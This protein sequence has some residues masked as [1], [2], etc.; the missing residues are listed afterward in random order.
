[1][2]YPNPVYKNNIGW[3]VF[4]GVVVTGA[5]M[6]AYGNYIVAWESRF[7]DGILTRKGSLLDYF[8]AKYYMLVSFCVGSYIIT[9]PY[10]FF[11]IKILWIQ[12][13]CFLFNIGINSL[14]VLWMS[15]YNRKRMELA[16]GSAF[17]WQGTG[18][19]QIIYI[20]PVMILP[21]VIVGIFNWM[22]YVNWG[23]AA[24]ALLGVI[25]LLC[26]KWFILYF[27]HR[28]AHTKYEQAEGFRKS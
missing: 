18:V 17:N 28:F 7:F 4:V 16:K 5:T 19:A 26:H 1:M 25:G 6:L 10:V 3:L 13:A 2:F 23:L 22:G 20:F 24:L 8:R 12:T 15:K 11:G 14:I 21:M 27:N 9:I